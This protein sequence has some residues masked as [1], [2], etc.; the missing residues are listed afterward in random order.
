[1]VDIFQKND[2]H[3]PSIKRTGY[4]VPHLDQKAIVIPSSNQAA[5]R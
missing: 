4:P 2:D 1:M 5:H 3:I